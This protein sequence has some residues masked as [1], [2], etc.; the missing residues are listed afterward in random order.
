MNRFE[1]QLLKPFII[2][3]ILFPVSAFAQEP[4]IRDSVG[5]D[6]KLVPAGAY[7][8]GYNRYRQGIQEIFKRDHAGTLNHAEEPPHTTH[9]TKPF[10]L[11]TR[12]VTVAQF[13]E[14]V[15]ATDYTTTAELSGDGVVGWHNVLDYQDNRR[16]RLLRRLP[17]FSWK[18][19]GFEQGDDH[20]VIG[21]SWKD[22]QAFCEW[23]SKKESGATYRLPTEAEWEYAC[24]AGTQTFF[25]FSDSHH[26]GIER[27]ANHADL[28]LENAH[29]DTA[30]MRWHPS[31]DDGAVFTSAAGSYEPNAWGFYDMHGNVWEMCQDLYLDVFY[32]HWKRPDNNTP[33]GYAVDPVNLSEPWNEAAD[34]RAIR[35]GCWRVSPTKCRSS[36]RAFFESSDGACYLGFRVARDAEGPA[37]DKARSDFETYEAA[38]KALQAN[39]AIQFRTDQYENM[40]LHLDINRELTAEIADHLPLMFRVTSL[41]ISPGGELPLEVLNAIGQMPQLRKLSIYHAGNH[42]PADA[43]EALAGLEQLEEVHLS[44]RSNLTGEVLSQFACLENL[45]VL[46]IGHDQM[47]SADLDPLAGKSWSNLK[48]LYLNY[49]NSDGSELAHFADAPLEKVRLKSLTDEG[50]KIV[51]QF[52]DLNSISANE[53]QITAVGLAELMKLT[54]LTS[55]GL[56]NLQQLQDSDFTGLENMKLLTSVSLGGSGAGDLTAES[57]TKIPRLRS[58]QI[59]SPAF[60]DRGMKLIGGIST[61]HHALQISEDA[62]VTDAGLEHLWAPDRLSTL[63][64]RQR[65]GIT[66]SG[67]GTM[68][69]NLVQLRHVE[70]YSGDFT[71]EGLKYLGYLPNL[72]N[73]KLFGSEGAG[74]AGVTGVGLRFLVESPRLNNVE[75]IGPNL[76]ITDEDIAAVK[77]QLPNLQLRI[78][79]R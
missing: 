25:S 4:A 35:G 44:N 46:N 64:L 27:F 3:S 16:R 57:L 18:E 69:E 8:R 75:I 65:T 47:Q 11:A 39:S 32:N 6:L 62:A 20:P 14:F 52:K 42:L 50:A 59:G 15:E 26:E 31:T 71:D 10:Y 61:L 30:A 67:L 51:G 78:E 19:P 13:R 38:F 21:V 1:M 12:E 37:V 79:K 29:E 77:A 33:N 66:G 55:I 70:I 41:N 74:L 17:K 54:K 45:R 9:I 43:F 49:M 58:L 36:F 24:R 56:S 28:A 68:S 76:Q 60:T 7:V 40:S 5:N 73:I 48:E 22:A 2:L 34:W 53:P 72:G 23:L 63:Y